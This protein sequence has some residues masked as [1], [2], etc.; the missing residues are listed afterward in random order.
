MPYEGIEMKK[1]HQILAFTLFIACLLIPGAHAPSS[2]TVVA[3][4]GST[5]TIDGTISS[6][7][8]DDASQ[9][10][11]SVSSLSDPC[12][13]YVKHDG[14][15]LYI[16]FNIPDTDEESLDCS[17]V[18]IDPD[19][20]EA[21]VF[22]PDDLLLAIYRDGTL[23]EWNGDGDLTWKTVS[24]TGWTGDYYSESTY[25]QTEYCIPYS[26]IGV[27]P[28]IDKT[29]GIAFLV[30]DSISPGYISS[31][32]WP[33]MATLPNTWGDLVSEVPHFAIPE[34]PFGTFMGLSM[35]LAAL[36]LFGLSKFNVRAAIK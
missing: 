23:N 2:T 17:R 10:T 20:D 7:E 21:T 14:S 30:Y 35:A 31:G 32:K 3:S 11:I 36:A 18:L 9:L 13:V 34:Y 22:M 25:W 1:L 6:G 5:P 24:Q 15:D 27:T 26:K 16:A 12:E 4:L 33:A 8:W 29:L 28:G 19:H